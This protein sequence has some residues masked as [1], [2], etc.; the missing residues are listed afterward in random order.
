MRCKICGSSSL[1]WSKGR[2]LQKFIIQYFRCEQCGFIQT[3]EPYWL[4]E[5]YAETI[6]RSD[7]GIVSRNIGMSKLARAIILSFFDCNARFLDYGGGYGLLVRLMRDHGLDFYRYDKYTSNLFAKGFDA[8]KEGNKQYELLTAFEVFEHLTSPLDEIM[9]MFLYSDNIL[10]STY[11]IPEPPP[12]LESWWYYSLDHGQHIALYTFRSL[13]VIAKKLNL[14]LYSNRKSFHLLT[15][16]KLTQPAFRIISN[17]IVAQ[18][19]NSLL[20]IR[21]AH[22]SLLSSDFL[23]LTGKYIG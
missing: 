18:F 16:K 3:E 15:E 10:F 22:Q 21:L 19:V 11:L 23:D 5:S 6:A 4:A 8:G 20:R 7:I 13:Q 17:R 12:A 1:A 14:K 9:E 2:I